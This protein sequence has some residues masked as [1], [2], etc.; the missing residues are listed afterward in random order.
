MQ[1]RPGNNREINNIREKGVYN[2]GT[3]Q[4]LQRGEH[5]TA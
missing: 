4:K 1:H 3:S 2:Y 5:R